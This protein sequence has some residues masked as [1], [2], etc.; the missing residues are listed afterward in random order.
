MNSTL[1]SNRTLFALVLAGPLAAFGCGDDSGMGT[2]GGMMVIDGGPGMDAPGTDGGMCRTDDDYY[3]G[4]DNCN[5][6]DDITAYMR[7]DY[8][9]TMDQDVSD[10]AAACG[11]GTCLT[12]VGS[13]GFA[14]C[15][16]TC[17]EDMTDVSAACSTCVAASVACSADNCLTEC[18]S[19]TTMDECNAC[20]LGAN[21]C[22][23]N[24]AMMFYTC[25]GLPMPPADGGVPTDGGATDAGPADGGST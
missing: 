9:A 23:A 18:I 13:A 1:L 10:I 2:D 3:S 22:S 24:C 5:N 19:P 20:R 11:R 14:G 6:A 8:G 7:E 21:D 16:A 15:V 4:T 17:V 25:S 12:M